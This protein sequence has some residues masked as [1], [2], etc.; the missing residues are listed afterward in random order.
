MLTVHVARLDAHIWDTNCRPENEYTLQ[1][2]AWVGGEDA[3][4]FLILAITI[5]ELER[6]I[7]GVQRR[8]AHGRAPGWTTT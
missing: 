1:I 2:A 6:G 7:L 8:D 5:L 3:A 4:S